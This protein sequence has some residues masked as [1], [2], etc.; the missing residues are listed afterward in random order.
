MPVFKV[1]SNDIVAES[2]L[3][4]EELKNLVLRTLPNPNKF[5]F[6]ECT[7]CLN[8]YIC[9]VHLSI[10]LMDDGFQYT[11]TF[12]DT[13]QLKGWMLY[14]GYCFSLSELEDDLK[15]MRNRLECRGFIPVSVVSSSD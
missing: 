12:C 3:S 9:R 2:T 1:L 14:G 11:A 6:A 4:E 10:Y 15:V 13:D 7:N 5:V 8:C